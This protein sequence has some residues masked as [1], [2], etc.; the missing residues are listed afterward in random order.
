MSG[1]EKRR[2]S[3]AKGGKSKANRRRGL[4]PPSSVLA[5][6]SVESPKGNRYRVLRTSETDETDSDRKEDG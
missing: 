2:S 1:E 6:L 3:A 4:P 5:E